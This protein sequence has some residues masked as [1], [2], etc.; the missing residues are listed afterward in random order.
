LDCSLNTASKPDGKFSSLLH[1]EG[2]GLLRICFEYV[3]RWG[4]K[5]FEGKFCLQHKGT[6]II[7]LTTGTTSQKTVKF[8]LSLVN[9]KVLETELGK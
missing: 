2:Y 9:R 8:I 7:Y 3:G 5:H 1:F 6:G 4:A